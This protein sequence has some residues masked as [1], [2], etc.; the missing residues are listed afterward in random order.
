M[1]IDFNLENREYSYLT[2]EDI[3]SLENIL[4]DNY[5]QLRV[6]PYQNIQNFSQNQVSLFCLK[7]A[8]YQIITQ[9]LVD[10]LKK[11]IKGFLSIEIGSGNGC[12]AKALGIPATD[13]FLQE[14]KEIKRIYHNAGQPTIRYGSE[15]KKQDAL[16]AIKLHKA[17]CAVG[18]WV[19]H[20]YKPRLQDGN[21]FGVDEMIL[22]KKLEKYIFI[23]NSE[24]HK[25]KELLRFC[26]PAAI[27]RE[28]LVSRS[29]RRENNVI[30]IFDLMNV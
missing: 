26:S 2:Q 28:W 5:G 16:T 12:L 8:V 22:A 14:R 20:K 1:D 23:G 10:F 17:N 9:E 27:K 29:M 21:K 13:N 4:L 30:W 24:T 18:S 7:H 19:T 3:T 6:V 11:E 15:V 25:N